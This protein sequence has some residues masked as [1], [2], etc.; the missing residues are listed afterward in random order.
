VSISGV[1]RFL[2][3]LRKEDDQS[4]ATHNNDLPNADALI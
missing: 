2:P 4:I 1:R 3:A